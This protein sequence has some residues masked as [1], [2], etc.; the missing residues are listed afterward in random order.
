MSNTW[1]GAGVAVPVFS[2]RTKAGL[3]VGEFLD[4]KLMVDWA[5]MCKMNLLQI[6]PIN[7]TTVFKDYRDSYPYR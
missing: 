1:K 2:L 3:G 4:L 7:D 6:L 5:A